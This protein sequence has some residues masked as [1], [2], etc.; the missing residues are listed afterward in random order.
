MPGPSS[1][2]YSPNVVEGLFSE[3]HLYRVLRSPAS[4]S[5]QMRLQGPSKLLH[6]EARVPYEGPKRPPLQLL[7][8]R[9]RQGLAP[10]ALHPDVGAALADGP[11]AKPSKGLN[12]FVA[13]DAGESRYSGGQTATRIVHSSSS[14]AGGSA[15]RSPSGS[16]S[17]LLSM[18]STVNSRAPSRSLTASRSVSPW[19]TTP[20]RDGVVAT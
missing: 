18:S 11:V 5:R 8:A 10:L 13:R 1:C 12:R 7:V 2:P 6:R 9:D 17:P 15:N 16:G 4:V 19:P 14:S 20:A 3:L